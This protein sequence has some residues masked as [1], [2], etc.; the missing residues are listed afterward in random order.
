MKKTISNP[1]QFKDFEI[2]LETKQRADVVLKTILR[3]IR[4]HYIN[5][6]NQSTNYIK[7][8]RGKGPDFFRE[9][10]KL[11]VGLLA[12]KDKSKSLKA[13]MNSTDFKS[14]LPKKTGMQGFNGEL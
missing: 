5:L 14:T 12:K 8:K 9:Q 7:S 13:K 6:F 1:N 10:L 4:R 2:H 3:Q 11:F